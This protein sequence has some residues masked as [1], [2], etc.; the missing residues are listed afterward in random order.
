MHV[1][2]QITSGTESART[3]AGH[4]EVIKRERATVERKGVSSVRI[5][6]E[7]TLHGRSKYTIITYR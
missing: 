4:E 3:R 5:T 2:V 6:A 1:G 7:N